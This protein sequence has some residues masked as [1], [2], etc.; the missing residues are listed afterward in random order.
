M[1]PRTDSPAF[2][3]TAMVML[4]LASFGSSYIFDSI[5]PLAKVLSTQ[6]HYTDADIGL[7][8]AVGSLPGVFMVLFAGIALDRVG[9]RKA[10]LAFVLLCLAGAIVTAA[11]PRLPVMLAGRLLFGLGISSLGV[12]SNAG[13][14]R[15]S[16]GANLS[17]VFSLNLTLSRLGSLAAQVSPA[18][19]RWAYASWRGPLL[20]GVGFAVLSV[21]AM[22]VYW[23]LEG[24]SSRPQPGPTVRR[25]GAGGGWGR[26][27]WLCV[28]VCVTFYAGIFPFQ[29]FAQKFFVDAHGV[30]PAR[31]S[32]LI[33]ALTFITM[34]LTPLFGLLVD[35]HGHRGLFLTAGCLL[36][37]PTYALMAHTRAS[38]LLPVALMGTAFS[39]VPAVLWPTVML[40]V[41]R[42]S[43]GR[44]FGT[45]SM[46]QSIGL[47][48]F[49]Y[50][51]GWAN[52]ANGAGPANPAGY[53][54]GM[55]LFTLASGAAVLLAVAFWRLERRAPGSRPLQATPGAS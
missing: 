37:A 39:L 44:A 18:W 10:G 31:A 49:N 41:P 33:G 13:I 1:T 48:A 43:L 36:L 32:L 9:V 42:E 28:L 40:I 24:R 15:W 11:S 38:L 26:A 17:F 19:A 54:P 34:I 14:A 25:Q 52:D 46:I 6:L 16:E 47:S 35:R 30:T 4:S 3:W 27:Y 29:T 20:L 22:L 51:I 7:L 55:G 8:Q 23:V 2:R 21:L 50:L 53:T 12:A 5:G 45:M